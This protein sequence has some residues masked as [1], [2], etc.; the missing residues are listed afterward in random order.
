VIIRRWQEASKKL[1][2]DEETK[3]ISSKQKKR[4]KED[5]NSSN[6]QRRTVLKQIKV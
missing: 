3:Q 5:V 4:S 1:S 6:K 2:F